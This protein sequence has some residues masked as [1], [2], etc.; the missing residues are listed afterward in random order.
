MFGFPSFPKFIVLVLVICAVYLW[1]RRNAVQS[2]SNPSGTQPGPARNEAARNG[3]AKANAASA[4][5]KQKSIEDLV[6][7]PSCGTY[8]AAGSSCSCGKGRR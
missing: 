8:I 7:C 4:N 6:K 2:R 3:A 1:S 5:A